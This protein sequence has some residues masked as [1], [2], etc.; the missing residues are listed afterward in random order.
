[1]A[2]IEPYPKAYTTAGSYQADWTGTKTSCRWIP[3]SALQN[4]N[5]LEKNYEIKHKEQHRGGWVGVF[6]AP[7]RVLA[8]V[9]PDSS[10]L[11]DLD[12]SQIAET[13][14]IGKDRQFDEDPRFGLIVLQSSNA[15]SKLSGALPGTARIL[16]AWGSP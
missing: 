14:L 16:P 8:Y 15:T 2:A 3:A 11:S 13:F 7:D 12:T 1:M 4:K 6:S 5:R 9:S 10:A